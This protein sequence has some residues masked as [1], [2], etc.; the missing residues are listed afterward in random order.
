M[1]GL[2]A[3][4]FLHQPAM[5]A[6]YYVPDDYL[7]IQGAVNAAWG[8]DEVIV[9]AGTYAGDG[10]KNIYIN[11]AITVRS[12]SG[13]ENTIIDCEG[14]G[15]GFH[16]ENMSDLNKLEGF[17][18]I[19]GSTDYG[20]GIMLKYASPVI[21]NCIINGN[22]ASG[23]GGG[24]Y[25]YG[26]SSLI[27]N[28]KIK[29]NTAGIVGGGIRGYGSIF[30][31]TNC[32]II[33]NS[34]THVD[35]G[36]GGMGC[37]Y[38]STSITNCTFAWNNAIHGAGLSVYSSPTDIHNSIFYF[39]SGLEEIYGTATV[40]YSNVRGGFTGEG[41]IDENPQFATG[42]DYH[43]LG[44]SPCID[45][46]SPDDA[47]D[48]D[49]DGELRPQGN[50]YDMGA[51]EYDGVPAP[52]PC[53]ADLNKDGVVDGFDLALFAEEYSRTDCCCVARH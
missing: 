33:G 42:G 52:P 15:R 34:A 1:A 7:T 48:I 5:S 43:L 25:G 37:T 4:V 16:F 39:N 6:T 22:T 30:S 53:K 18:I 14:N 8:G 44:N 29:G 9:R 45:M 20:G 17:Q 12:E 49:L 46:A 2:A 19:N 36:A 23:D 35:G 31:I 32:A 10:N 41:N 26:S 13:S 47:P 27:I 3:I 21:R 38:G 28:C 40:V 50:G 51:D 24:I 11:K